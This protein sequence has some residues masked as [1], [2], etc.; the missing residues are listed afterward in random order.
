MEV[1]AALRAELNPHM[2][3]NQETQA[4]WA[5]PEAGNK[6]TCMSAPL[7]RM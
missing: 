1:L 5:D 7:E 6:P 2:L 4:T 3:L